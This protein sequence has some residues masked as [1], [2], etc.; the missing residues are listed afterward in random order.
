MLIQR[1]RRRLPGAAPSFRNAR[2]ARIEPGRLFAQSS[3]R[4]SPTL[5]QPANAWWQDEGRGARAKN[6][7]KKLDETAPD[8]S[9]SKKWRRNRSRSF[10]FSD[11]GRR[12]C[13]TCTGTGGL[14]PLLG[15]A[16][17]C[18]LFCSISQTWGCTLF[19]CIDICYIYP[20]TFTICCG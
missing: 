4:R 12:R 3:G 8:W 20:F 13:S 10:Y 15:C 7:K 17:I 5:W 11:P 19:N 16:N 2:T 6:T 14:V 18:A 9:S 1:L